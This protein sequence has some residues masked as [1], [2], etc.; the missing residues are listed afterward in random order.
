MAQN[1]VNVDKEFEYFDIQSVNDVWY[2]WYYKT[3]RDGNGPT[4]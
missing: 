3:I 1:N 4:E 2:A